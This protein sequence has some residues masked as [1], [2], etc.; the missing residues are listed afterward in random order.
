MSARS[1]SDRRAD[2]RPIPSRRGIITSASTRS[3]VFLPCGFERRQSV[4]RGFDVP[5]LRKHP[6]EMLAHVGIVIH[7][8]Q[9]R[10]LTVG[11]DHVRLGTEV[12]NHSF[13]NAGRLS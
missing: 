4:A 10:P 8:Q 7:D 13:G 3:G 9:A 1:G 6:T 12:V 2:R 5:P 11:R